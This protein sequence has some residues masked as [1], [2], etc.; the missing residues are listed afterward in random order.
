MHNRPQSHQRARPIHLHRGQVHEEYGG[1][2]AEAHDNTKTHGHSSEERAQ[3]LSLEGSEWPDPAVINHELWRGLME[4][5]P[6]ETLHSPEYLDE[7][8][9][10][11]HRSNG[12]R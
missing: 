5:S 12:T 11:P 6:G 3:S 10:P 4:E 2:T 9:S 1:R 8:M 7:R